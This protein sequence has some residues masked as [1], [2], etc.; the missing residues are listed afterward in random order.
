VSEQFLYG[1]TTVQLRQ[2]AFEFAESN[3][4]HHNFDRSARAAGTDWPAGFLKRNQEISLHMPE[5]MS[6]AR[7]QGFNPVQV[8]NFFILLAELYQK[9]TGLASF[10][11]LR[12]K[13][14]F[15]PV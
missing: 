12:F 9:H 2:L 8:E 14:R 13:P 3:Q 1:L 4:L 5:M 10:C 15:K 11:Q 7:M 6:L